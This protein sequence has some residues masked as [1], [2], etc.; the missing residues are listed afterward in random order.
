MLHLH[1]SNSLA[2]SSPWNPVWQ[3]HAIGGPSLQF[4]LPLHTSPPL[5]GQVVILQRSPVN[6]LSHSQIPLLPLLH[7]PWPLH[8]IESMPKKVLNY[9]DDW[10]KRHHANLQQV[11]ELSGSSTQQLPA[12]SGSSISF[13]VQRHW[14][15][16]FES[17]KQQ[18]TANE[19]SSMYYDCNHLSCQ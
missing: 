7:V 5:P 11:P 13:P 2:Q 19:K 8:L 1:I 6:P 17:S 4:P 12:L 9:Y 14:P 3:S 18:P 16:L 15:R 10:K